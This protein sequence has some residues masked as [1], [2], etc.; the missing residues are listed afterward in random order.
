MRKNTGDNAS[1]A[2]LLRND[3]RLKAVLDSADEFRLQVIYTRIDRDERNQPHFTDFLYDVDTTRYFYP[4]STVKMPI[5]LAA[6][7]KL[8]DLNIP[9][10]TKYTPMYT[11]NLPGVNT[12][13]TADSTAA[14]GQPS[15][16][17]YIKK[18]F[19]V[20]DNDAANRLYEFVG[21]QPLNE[22]LWQKGYT[23]AQIRHRLDM[24]GLSAEANR[25]TNGVQFRHNGRLLYVQPERYS[26]LPFPQRSDFVGL[27]HVENGKVVNTPFDFSLRNRITL[28]DLHLLL[29]S[30]IFPQHVT[31]DRL[32]RLTEDDYQFLY[33]YMSQ[34]P[35]ETS[36]PAYD[37]AAFHHNYV[38]FLLL[39]GEKTEKPSPGLRIYNKPGWAYGFLTDVAYIADFE[40]NVEFLLSATLYVNR[41]GII[42]DDRYDF[43]TVGKPFLKA[44]GEVIYQQELQRERK[45]KPDLSRYKVKYEKQIN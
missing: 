9:G 21:Q 4:A 11:D 34:G 26:A 40:H 20:S 42:G 27:A 7:E 22:G 30:I 13:V 12:A 6:L 32:F 2:K 25:H 35:D 14:D 43:E 37:T 39:G 24:A 45:Y 5:A 41:D 23:T 44:P 8:N 18:I 10:L 3:P 38:K 17:H 15:V 16:A 36:Y 33:R 19:L 29:K 1:F 28:P 31:S